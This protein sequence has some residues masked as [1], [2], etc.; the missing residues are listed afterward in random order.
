VITFETSI[1]PSVNHLYR[2]GE[3]GSVHKTDRARC[4]ERELGW[5]LAQAGAPR[6][7]WSRTLVGIWVEFHVKARRIDWDG[8]LKLLQDGIAEYVGFDD[9][10]VVT[11]GVR[12]RF[13]GK[14][15]REYLRVRVWRVAGEWPFGEK[16]EG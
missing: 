5:T 15:E 8:I 12:K 4:F 1:P 7:G 11:G 9:K 6:E 16:R 14:G 3:R 13:V 10:A 2:R